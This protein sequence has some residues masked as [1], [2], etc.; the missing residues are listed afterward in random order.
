MSVRLLL[1]IALPSITSTL[2]FGLVHGTIRYVW[3]FST[4]SLAAME[5][6]TVRAFLVVFI[7]SASLLMGCASTKVEVGGK[8]LKEPLCRAGGQPT[9]VLVYWTTQWRAD[10]K[11]PELREAAAHRGLEDFFSRTNCLSVVATER[12]S[13][14]Q[15]LPD[16]EEVVRLAARRGTLPDRIVLVAVRELG[17]KLTIGIPVIVEGGT[18]VL[19]DV[20]VL[21]PVPPRALADVQTLWRNGGTFVVKGVKTLDRDMSA[22]L[23]ATLMLS[24]SVQ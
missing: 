17:P 19:I 2:L 15:A 13:P 8:P 12:L 3:I 18:E 6:L 14:G 5:Q 1:R 9:S 24:Q 4:A 10:Q 16:D 11:E 21:D 22:A 7:T 23:N 20:R